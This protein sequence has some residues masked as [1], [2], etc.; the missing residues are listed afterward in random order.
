MGTLAQAEGGTPSTCAGKAVGM[1]SP[2]MAQ[3]TTSSMT[4]N[5]MMEIMSMGTGVVQSAK[6][7]KDG[8]VLVEMKPPLQLAQKPVEMASGPM[9]PEMM[10]IP[11]MVMDEAA[12][13]RWNLGGTEILILSPLCA[14]KLQSRVL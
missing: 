9:L 10:R 2:S 1:G 12:P 5:V 7:R 6:L 11:M 3:S 4:T 13:V 14:G 8:L